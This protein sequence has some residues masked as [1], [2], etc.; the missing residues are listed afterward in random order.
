MAIVGLTGRGAG[1]TGY[2]PRT[3]QVGSSVTILTTARAQGLHDLC[4]GRV[5]VG[6]A[7]NL[8]A[9]PGSQ[10]TLPPVGGACLSPRWGVFLLNDL[11]RGQFYFLIVNVPTTLSNGPNTI[12]VSF[13]GTSYGYYCLLASGST[14]C[15]SNGNFDPTGGFYYFFLPNNLPNVPYDM[16]V[17]LGGRLPAT[18]TVPSTTPPGL[19]TGTI[20][21]TLFY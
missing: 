10:A 21:L 8:P 7:V 13:A 18:G 3:T 6:Q 1:Q 11:V 14:N 9:P 20:T 16:Y 5:P 12:S 19:Y 17:Y 15:I 4:F 2:G